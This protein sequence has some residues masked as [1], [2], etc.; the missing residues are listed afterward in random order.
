MGDT[1]EG[2]SNGARRIRLLLPNDRA[3]GDPEKVNARPFPPAL[4][5]SPAL[6]ETVEQLQ[7]WGGGA[8]KGEPPFDHLTISPHLARVDP[9]VVSPI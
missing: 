9:T 1:K 4:F 2:W 6:F 8:K 5:V 7:G 3:G